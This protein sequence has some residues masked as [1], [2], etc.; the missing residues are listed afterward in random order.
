MT[1]YWKF[2]DIKVVIKCRRT[3]TNGVI[4]VRSHWSEMHR[5]Q[6]LRSCLLYLVDIPG[7]YFSRSKLVASL[8]SSLLCWTRSPL[9][10]IS[11]WNSFFIFKKKIHILSNEK[12]FVPLNNETFDHTSH[13]YFIQYRMFSILAYFF[14]SWLPAYYP[15]S[16][17]R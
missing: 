10:C 13:N 9:I 8:S 5:F 4:A 2:A 11:Q 7:F 15:N 17:G 6:V 14:S 16:K 3:E 1:D 12:D